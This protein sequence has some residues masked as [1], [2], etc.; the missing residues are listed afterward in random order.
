MTTAPQ[1]QPRGRRTGSATHRRQ[2]ASDGCC[3]DAASTHLPVRVRCGASWRSARKTRGDRPVQRVSDG[4]T[5][6]S[7]SSST[8]WREPPTAARD[9]P[10]SRHCQAGV[11]CVRKSSLCLR[12]EVDYLCPPAICGASQHAGIAGQA[13]AISTDACCRFAAAWLT[14]AAANV[15]GSSALLL[16]RVRRYRAA[17]HRRT[18]GRRRLPP[19]AGRCDPHRSRR[20]HPVGR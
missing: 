5:V 1:R 18:P 14:S 10:A 20:V 11:K 13:S 12:I 7:G 15:P 19:R 2:Q 9:R 3:N 4:H 16:H 6:A 17:R 8:H